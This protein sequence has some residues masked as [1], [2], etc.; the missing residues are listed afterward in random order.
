MVHGAG[1]PRALIGAV[2][3][4][5]WR[6]DRN[7]ALS[8]VSA[9]DRYYLDSLSQERLS[10]ILVSVLAGFGLL[11]GALGIY[12]TL[13]FSVGTR[14]REIGIRMALGA[15]PVD[16]L[17]LTLMAGLRLSAIATV[18]GMGVAWGTVGFWLASFRRLARGIRG[19]YWSCG[20]LTCAALLAAYVPARRAAG[21]DPLVA[22]R[23]E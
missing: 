14:V 22:L 12:G 17:R 6:V 15:K 23:S 16:V 1:D 13:S 11:L 2:Q 3:E 5:V 21:V 19:L 7:L 8:K 20:G 4:A 9:L 10:T 18:L